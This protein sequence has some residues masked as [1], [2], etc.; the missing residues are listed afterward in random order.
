VR[1]WLRHEALDAAQDRLAVTGVG[2]KSP[3]A[4]QASAAIQRPSSGWSLSQKVHRQ[5]AR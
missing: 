3:A 1:R 2:G 5:I 4:D